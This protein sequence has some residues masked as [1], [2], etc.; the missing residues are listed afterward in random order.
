M[1]KIANRKKKLTIRIVIICL[2]VLLTFFFQFP[3]SFGISNTNEDYSHILKDVYNSNSNFGEVQVSKIAMLGSHDALANGISYSSKPDTARQR[4][5]HDNFAANPLINILA[6]GLVVRMSKAQSQNI[7]EQLKAG[8]RFIDV[9]ISD[10]DGEFYNCHGVI[11][12]RLENNLLLILKFLDENP[13]E[14][15]IFSILYYYQDTR[16]WD[17]MCDYIKSVEYNGHNI[18]DYVNYDTKNENF[19][20][21]TYN[22]VT[23]SS[24]KAGV[25]FVANDYDGSRYKD[26]FALDKFINSNCKVSNYKKIDKVID[27]IVEDSKKYNDS[28]LKVNQTQITPD[29]DGIL[30]VF[31]NWSL[32]NISDKHNSHVIQQENYKEWIDSMPIYLTDNSTSNINDFNHEINEYII[33]HNLELASNYKGGQH[34]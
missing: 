15:I 13:G 12:D 11:S 8:T 16:S 27:Q 30:S 2:L 10:I 4:A 5:T 34:E 9:R 1:M 24:C 6:K 20:T 32:L 14:F 23:S 28:Y 29:V 18:F 17:E 31:V 25:V 21:L 19:S 26:Y 33:E 22:D 7:Y 3:L